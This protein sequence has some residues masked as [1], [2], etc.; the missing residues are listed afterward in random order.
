RDWSSDVCSSD[1]QGDHYVLDGAKQWTTNAGHADFIVV[2][3]A[4]D[5]S[6]RHAGLSAFI[7]DRDSPGLRLG[8]REDMAGMRCADTRSLTLDAC[9][10]PADNLLGREGDGFRVAQAGFHHSRPQI[11]AAATGI[12]RAAMEHATRYAIERK[13]GGKL[14]T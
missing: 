3:A 7:V 13:A 4:T 14:L 8:P 11:A 1:L 5:P 9:V 10:V 6:K 12:A 2:F